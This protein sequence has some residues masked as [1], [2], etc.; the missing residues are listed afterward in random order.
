MQLPANAVRRLLTVREAAA[1]PGIAV[2]CTEKTE[3]SAPGDRDVWNDTLI[4]IVACR[5]L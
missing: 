5:V 1:Y 3:G 2:N 4:Q